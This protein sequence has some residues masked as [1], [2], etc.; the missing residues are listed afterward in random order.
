MND[1]SDEQIAAFEDELSDLSEKD[2]QIHI[3]VELMRIRSSLEIIATP[4]SDTE[5]ETWYKCM[6][7]KDKVPHSDIREH[8]EKEHNAPPNVDLEKMFKVVE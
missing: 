2:L 8:A 7:C 1:F 5:S 3:L 4:Q 6:R